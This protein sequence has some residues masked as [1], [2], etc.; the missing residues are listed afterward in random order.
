MMASPFDRTEAMSAAPPLASVDASERPLPLLV[1][2]LGLDDETAEAVAAA[3]REKGIDSRH[4]ERADGWVRALDEALPG[5]LLV[6][7]AVAAKALELLDKLALRNAGAGAVALL[8]F[9]TLPQ[10][11]ELLLGGVEGFVETSA[12]ERFAS[13]VTAWVLQQDSAAPHVLLVASDCDERDPMVER[14]RRAGLRVDVLQAVERILAQVD[15]RQP[16]AIVFELGS[17]ALDIVALIARLRAHPSARS[18]PIL[19]HCTEAHA[20]ARFTSQRW[21]ADDVLVEPL[22]PRV[23]GAAVRSHVRRMRGDMRAPHGIDAKQARRPRGEFL[24]ELE[25]RLAAHDADWCVLLALRVDQADLR[26]RLGLSA[27]YALERELAERLKAL[28]APGD[29]FS[30]WEEFGFGLL[31]TRAEPAQIEAALAALLAAVAER[32]FGIGAEALSLSVSVGF[33]LP[34]RERRGNCVDRWIASAFAALAMAQRLGGGRAEGVLSRDPNALPPERIMVIT[35]ALKD[36]S[37]GSSL[38][39]EFQALAAL[40]DE[41]RHHF[42]LIAKLRD[43]RSPLQGYPRHEYLALAR[44]QGQLATIDRM[45]LFHAFETIAELQHEGHDVRVLVPFDLAAI[46]ERQLAWLEAE[47]RR[48]SALR[49]TLLLELDAGALLSD[50]HASAVARL[51]QTGVMFAA[52][53]DFP[54]DELFD[55][56]AAQPVDLLRL[57]YTQIMAMPADEFGARVGSW[58]ALGRH[59]LVDRVESL[60]AVSGLWNLGIDYLQGDALAGASPRPELDHGRPV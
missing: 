33:A 24:A 36:L 40:R 53:G 51:Q 8:A 39:F 31:I 12:P 44:T 16:G 43:L 17:R 42:A 58:H 52:G 29:C 41:H 37:R 11:L 14:L 15:A 34:P 6:P 30:L 4:F 1:D 2:L 26:K 9:G 21:G 49:E 57:S 38:R 7:A 46:D 23:L 60:Q 13:D 45:S 55:A 48:R 3:L 35:Q 20:S 27:A 28:L 18:L 22:H 19:L 32:P 47:L 5:V 56:L 54:A 50:E 59:L 25:Q 10:R